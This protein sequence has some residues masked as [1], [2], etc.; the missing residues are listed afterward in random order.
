[1]GKYDKYRKAEEGINGAGKNVN[2]KF[3]VICVI[4]QQFRGLNFW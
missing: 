2:G 4:K 1:M 3:M